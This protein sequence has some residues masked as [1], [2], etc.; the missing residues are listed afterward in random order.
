MTDDHG[1]YALLVEAAR[2]VCSDP[3]STGIPAPKLA[4]LRAGLETVGEDGGQ[5]AGFGLY[6][7]RWRWDNDAEAHYGA[8]RLTPAQADQIRSWLT[9]NSSAIGASE[10]SVEPLADALDFLSYEDLLSQWSTLFVGFDDLGR[11][12]FLSEAILTASGLTLLRRAP[13][14]EST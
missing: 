10:V 3:A 7:I 12:R 8:V 5:R 2:S 6:V 13:V 11:E 1:R 14:V 4:A 9:R